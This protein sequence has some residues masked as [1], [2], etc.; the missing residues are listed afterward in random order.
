VRAKTFQ[1]LGEQDWDLISIQVG[2]RSSKACKSR[3]EELVERKKKGRFSPK[4]DF[5]LKLLVRALHAFILSLFE[6]QQYSI[7][8]ADFFKRAADLIPKR[9][10]IQLRE[11]WSNVLD[12]SLRRSDWLP[13][14]DALLKEA[15]RL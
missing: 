15:V 12:P 2:T 1:L 10:A 13:A 9:D 3:Y 14:E 5:Q 7:Y 11:R 4:E 8:G 6:A